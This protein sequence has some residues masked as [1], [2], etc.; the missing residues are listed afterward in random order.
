MILLF[1]SVIWQSKPL[2]HGKDWRVNRKSISLIDGYVSNIT[3]LFIS[4]YVIYI[5]YVTII[6]GIVVML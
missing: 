3:G 5:I 2:I 4:K 1:L 6:K